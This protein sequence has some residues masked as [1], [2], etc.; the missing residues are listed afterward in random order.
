MKYYTLVVLEAVNALL[1]E[2]LKMITLATKLQQ[3]VELNKELSNSLLIQSFFPNIF[4]NGMV[5]LKSFGK[6]THSFQ[7]GVLPYK[8]YF[9]SD[10][11][12]TA[13]QYLTLKR[14]F[15]EAEQKAITKHWSM[16]L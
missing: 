2:V 14:E 3:A 16:K 12:L 11:R 9:T 1:R 15:N 5:T 4:D 8:A 10:H 13:K 6:S 7:T